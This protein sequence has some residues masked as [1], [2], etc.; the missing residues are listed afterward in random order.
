[1]DRDLRR[2]NDVPTRRFLAEILAVVTVSVALAM[3][4]VYARTTALVDGTALATARSYTDLIVATRSWNASHGG[5][6]VPKDAG[7]QTNPFLA[8]MGVSVDATTT[9]GRVL[10]LRNPAIMT[11]EISAVLRRSDGTYFRLTSLKPVNPANAP[12]S[13]E[14]AVLLDFAAGANERWETTEASGVPEL[15]YMRALVTDASCLTCHARQGYRV[16]D[17]RGAVSVAV[18]LAAQHGEAAL[19]AGLIGGVGILATIVLLAVTLTLVNRLRGQ[20]QRAQAA[21]VEAATVDVLTNAA[22]RRQTMARLQVEIDR[23]TRTHDPVAL[24]MIDIDRFKAVND[25]HGHATGDAVLA[26][27]S[28]RVRDTLRPYDVFGRLGGEEFL[29]I[30]P[31]TGLDEAVAIAERARAAVSSARIDAGPVQVAL[32]V[33]LGVTLVEPGEDGALDHALAR[34]DEALYDAKANGRDR[35]S[36]SPPASEGT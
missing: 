2:A 22:T 32:T 20:L 14:R 5:V 24:V 36:V 33:S 13:W 19:N 16:G 18:P 26:E 1:L 34:V 4:G 23:A 3:A 11:E 15:R 6:W 28:R 35:T 27:V 25:A 9:D 29:I 7:T 17:I 21:L 12:D 30:S 8:Q 31:E 10:T